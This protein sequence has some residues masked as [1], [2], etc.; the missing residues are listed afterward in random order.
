MNCL[1]C[2]KGIP[3]KRKY[4]SNSCQMRHSNP[5]KRVEVADKFR[6]NNNPMRRPEVSEK[7]RGDNSWKRTEEAR[8]Q[9]RDNNPMTNPIFKARY[10]K[11]MT[12]DHPMRRPEIAKKVSDKLKGRIFSDDHKQKIGIKSL[13]RNPFANIIHPMKDPAIRNKVSRTRIMNGCSL[14]AKNWNWKGG[15][16]KELYCEIWTNKTFKDYLKEKDGYVCQNCGVTQRLSLKVYSKSLTSHHINY[17]KQDCQESNLI[18]LCLGC[19]TKANSNREYWEVFYTD[20]K[21][22]QAGVLC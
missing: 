12:D 17:D 11:K 20:K 8:Q 21:Q 5:M 3:E 6:G 2:N 13:G 9:M 22:I 10:L 19:N 1:N 16:S 4:C 14:G 15:I 7:F 18:T